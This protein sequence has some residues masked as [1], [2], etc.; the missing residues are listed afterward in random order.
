MRPWFARIYLTQEFSYKVRKRMNQLCQELP[1]LSGLT[2]RLSNHADLQIKDTLRICSSMPR[3]RSL[4]KLDPQTSKSS[5]EPNLN[6]KLSEITTSNTKA[7]NK[8]NELRQQMPSLQPRDYIELAAI[9][10]ARGDTTGSGD[11]R[12]E[13]RTLNYE[14]K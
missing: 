4:A 1:V 3:T 14:P 7:K 10:K 2:Y 8:T 6:T 13:S 12:F 5:R 9:L 11:T